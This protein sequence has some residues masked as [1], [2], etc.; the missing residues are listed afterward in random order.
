MGCLDFSW[1]VS[2]CLDLSQ[3]V[4][5]CLDLSQLVSTCLDLSQLVSTCLDLS[6]LVS[7]C[8]DWSWFSSIYLDLSWLVW[9]CLEFFLIFL[10]LIFIKSFDLD[11]FLK[12]SLDSHEIFESFITTFQQISTILMRSICLYMVLI[13]SLDLEMVVF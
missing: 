3:F 2:I 13:K 1:F 11:M 12:V 10:D 4:L 7:I 8:L 6:R 9:I 5:T